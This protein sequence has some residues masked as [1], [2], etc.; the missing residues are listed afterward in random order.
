[1]K[2]AGQD[3]FFKAALS[4]VAGSGIEKNGVLILKSIPGA[5]N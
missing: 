5:R 3:A 4:A 1:M 2:L